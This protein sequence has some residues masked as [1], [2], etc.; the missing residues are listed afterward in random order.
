MN[1]P[2]ARLQYRARLYCKP[3]PSHSRPVNCV[4]FD[5]LVPVTLGVP[6]GS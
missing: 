6:N 1:R 3:V 2:I 4:G 5:A